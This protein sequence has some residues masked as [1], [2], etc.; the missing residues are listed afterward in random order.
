MNH[1]HS[2]SVQILLLREETAGGPLLSRYVCILF[3]GIHT[4]GF[5]SLAAGNAWLPPWPSDRC[6]LFCGLRVG[7][8][9]NTYCPLAIQKPTQISPRVLR[10]EQM[11][12]AMSDDPEFGSK[13][14][15]P[16]RQA[17]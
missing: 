6:S 12:K 7:S 10:L 8:V 11:E 14:P 9:G 3:I 5:G 4:F 17:L 1:C 13:I 16:S 15:K 2:K